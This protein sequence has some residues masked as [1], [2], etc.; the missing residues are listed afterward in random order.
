MKSDE[1]YKALQE[2]YE[3]WLA[4]LDKSDCINEA[5]EIAVVK[6]I[7]NELDDDCSLVDFEEDMDPSWLLD[8]IIDYAVEYPVCGEVFSPEAG[9]VIDFVNGFIE[10]ENREWKQYRKDHHGRYDD[11]H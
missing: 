4:S 3:S 10:M 2:P 6:A 1:M 7:M 5:Y 8:E 11:N 9:D